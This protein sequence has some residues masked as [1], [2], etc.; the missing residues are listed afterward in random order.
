[1]IDPGTIATFAS[2]AGSIGGLFGKKKRGPSFADMQVMEDQQIRNRL[3]STMLGAKEAGIHPLYALGAP[4]LQNPGV[5]IGGSEGPERD[6]A[7]AGQNIGTALHRIS[8]SEERDLARITARQAVE[9]GQLENELLKSQIAQIRSS[10]TP[11][12]NNG[13]SIIPGQAQGKAAIA[14]M[15]TP[16][17]SVDGLLPLHQM[18]YDEDGNPVR[19]FNT[20]D[21]GDNELAQALHTIRYTVPDYLS[22]QFRP[23]REGAAR[24]ASN[25][26]RN[27]KR[28]FRK[29]G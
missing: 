12:I 2:I 15:S 18:S 27:L 14:G 16:Y 4:V 22:A 1:M 5:S 6:W 28:L 25:L 21:L 9:R 26:R 11:S 7:S 24:F 3:M 19:L 23:A 29:G 8:T 10:W 20:N 13:R 17:G